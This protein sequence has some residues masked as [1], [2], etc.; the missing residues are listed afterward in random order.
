M[1]EEPKNLELDSVILQLQM[2]MF[3]IETLRETLLNIY[4]NLCRDCEEKFRGHWPLENCFGNL[5]P[6]TP[7]ENLM[8]IQ[9]QE[10]SWN[11]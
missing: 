6:Q 3:A 4:E 8:Q 7:S 10:K 5:L 2:M 1:E 9:E 11:R